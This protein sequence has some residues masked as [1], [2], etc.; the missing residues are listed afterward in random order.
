MGPTWK[1]GVGLQLHGP[2][3]KLCPSHSLSHSLELQRGEQLGSAI[4]PCCQDVLAPTGYNVA[5]FVT[6]ALL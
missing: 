2:A 6:F 5:D 1:E 4:G 3:D